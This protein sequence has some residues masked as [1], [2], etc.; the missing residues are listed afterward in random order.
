MCYLLRCTR[1]RLIQILQR[2]A[3]TIYYRSV[4][5]ATKNERP[6][7][8][9]K[10]TR[11]NDMKYRNVIPIINPTIREDKSVCNHSIASRYRRQQAQASP[12]AK[13][14]LYSPS[15][16]ILDNKIRGSL[17]FTPCCLRRRG[18]AGHALASATCKRDIDT[19]LFP[20][21]SCR[22]SHCE[23]VAVGSSP[24]L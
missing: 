7:L 3:C 5:I 16:T 21:P 8:D 15:P 18:G 24:P 4:V 17:L 2:E 12:K 19:L 13:V 22:G 20:A 1:I 23:T 14:T 6:C 10:N 9:Q 11:M